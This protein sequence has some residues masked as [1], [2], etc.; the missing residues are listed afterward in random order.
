[1]RK[2]FLLRIVLLLSPDGNRASF[3]NRL[4]IDADLHPHVSRITLRSAAE[5]L[6]R[7]TRQRVAAVVF[8]VVRM[9]FDFDPFDM[10]NTAQRQ[11][12]LPKILIFHRLF[13]RRLPTVSLPVIDPM[14]TKCVDQIRAV[15]IKLH[16]ARKL[17]RF[18]RRDRAD[19]LHAVVGRQFLA[20]R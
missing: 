9:T 20:V 4:F 13:R 2:T 14:V 10:V 1:M 11:Q 15:R 3:L 8:F 7:R 18:E 19:Q 5:L 16:V 17:Q 6:D 12:F